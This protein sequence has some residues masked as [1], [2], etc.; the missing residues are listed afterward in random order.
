MPQKT[1]ST[2]KKK[3][4]TGKS[5]ASKPKRV[6]EEIEEEI[7]LTEVYDLDAAIAEATSDKEKTEFA[8]D[9]AGESWTFRPASQSD[10][11]LLIEA[12]LSEMQQVMVY[13]KDLL[14]EEQW[15][16][17]PR[18]TFTG[19]LLLIERY[20]EFTNGVTM[21]EVERSTDS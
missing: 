10:A 16:R 20:S 14:G 18:I 2:A 12:D 17:F 6:E 11:K 4:T 7:D 9:Y 5:A 15:A 1:K 13:I 3:A 21:G 8:F 19:A